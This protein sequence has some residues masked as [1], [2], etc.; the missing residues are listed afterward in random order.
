[1]NERSFIYRLGICISFNSDKYRNGKAYHV[2][3]SNFTPH[4]RNQQYNNTTLTSVIHLVDMLRLCVG[5]LIGVKD[6][7]YE[8]VNWQKKEISVQ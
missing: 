3:L 4:V 7:E 6:I 8:D 1:M 2:P 5:G